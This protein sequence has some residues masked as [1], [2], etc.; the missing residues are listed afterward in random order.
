MNDFREGF[1]TLKRAAGKSARLKLG[2]AKSTDGAISS[3]TRICG[4]YF[5]TR[6]TSNVVKSMGMPSRSKP[7]KRVK[8]PRAGTAFSLSS[9]SVDSDAPKMGSKSL[10]TLKFRAAKSSRFTANPNATAMWGRN[11][12]L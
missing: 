10:F 11:F 3:A 5:S 7:S 9:S 2:G 1:D 4:R 6:K 8:F 12:S